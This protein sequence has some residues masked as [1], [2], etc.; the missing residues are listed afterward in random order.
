MINILE[1]V[2]STSVSLQQVYGGGM[3]IGTV[4]AGGATEARMAH[5]FIND[6]RSEARYLTRQDGCTGRP[7]EAILG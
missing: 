5:D 6:E 4:L 1:T 3:F 7:G 2:C